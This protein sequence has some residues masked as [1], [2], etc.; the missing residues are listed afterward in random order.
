MEINAVLLVI[1]PI[2]IPEQI[3]SLGSLMHVVLNG[4]KM[5]ILAFTRDAVASF[6]VV[7]RF[8]DF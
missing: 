8:T 5:L 3:M 2:A 4:N 7:A 1:K 6:I